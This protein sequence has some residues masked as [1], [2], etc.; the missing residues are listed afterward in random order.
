M[1]L[2]GAGW[3]QTFQ[4]GNPYNGLPR[5]SN[6]LLSPSLLSPPLLLSVSPPMLFSSRLLSA[7]LSG[8]AGVMAAEAFYGFTRAN[9]SMPMHT[10]DLL[11]GWGPSR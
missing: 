2:N 1:A 11:V 7:G 9:E 10:A 4:G 8:M 3:G 5:S 6:S